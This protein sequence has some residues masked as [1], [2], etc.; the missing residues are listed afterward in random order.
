MP[1]PSQ[2]PASFF[3]GYALLARF[4]AWAD[5][6]DSEP[7]AEVFS[8]SPQVV[9]VPIGGGWSFFTPAEVGFCECMADGTLYADSGL[10]AHQQADPHCSC[11]A[12]LQAHEA[13]L[14]AGEAEAAAHE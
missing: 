6:Q 8:L 11:S 2:S 14:N 10:A 4:N 5:W 12:C 3:P 13:S 7:C 1:A 9:K